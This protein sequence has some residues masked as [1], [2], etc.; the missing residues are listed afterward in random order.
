MLTTDYRPYMFSEFLCADRLDQ[1][2]SSTVSYALLLNR[3]AAL[4][5]NNHKGYPGLPQLFAVLPD[6]FVEA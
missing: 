5:R 4:R 1:D 3:W 6:G 2:A